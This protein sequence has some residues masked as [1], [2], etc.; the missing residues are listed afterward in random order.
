MGYKGLLAVGFKAL[1]A[2]FFV[3]ALVALVTR[4]LF[5]HSAVE[6]EGRVSSFREIHNVGPFG[7]GGRAATTRYYPQVEYETAEGEYI[8][9]TLGTGAARQQMA[10]GAPIDLLYNPRS[11]ERAIANDFR[12]RWYR[13][14]VFTALGAF[15]ALTGFLMPYAFQSGE[16][17]GRADESDGDVL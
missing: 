4:V 7:V 16:R 17:R 10:I 8:M 6:V 1:A 2:L 13:A 3:C 14:L 5:L 9:V 15:F 12:N 11:P